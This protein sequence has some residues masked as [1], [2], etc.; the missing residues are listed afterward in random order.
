MTSVEVLKITP[1]R[2]GN[3]EAFVKLRIGE[4][5]IHDFRII[6]QRGQRPWVSAPIVSW[7]DTDGSTQYKTL[8]DFPHRLKDAVSDAVLTAWKAAA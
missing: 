6:Q 8:I 1:V 2:N 5:V 4:T 3:L 7:I